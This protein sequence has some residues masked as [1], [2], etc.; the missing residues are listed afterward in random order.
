MSV[1]F[2]PLHWDFLKTTYVVRNKLKSDFFQYFFPATFNKNPV[3]NKYLK[4]NNIFNWFK[5]L[6][7]IC[8]KRFENS[9]GLFYSWLKWWNQTYHA[10]VYINRLD[11]FFYKIASGGDLNISNFHNIPTNPR[12]SLTLFWVVFPFLQ[13]AQIIIL[14]MSRFHS[15]RKN[16]LL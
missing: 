6:R 16:V 10:I 11:R 2:W 8:P 1:R 5:C 14:R 3:L 15:N 4:S 12:Y 13:R 7:M 9:D